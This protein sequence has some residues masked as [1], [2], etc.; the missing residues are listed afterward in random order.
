MVG[1]RSRCY[2]ELVDTRRILIVGL[3]ALG[4]GDAADNAGPTQCD[5]GKCDNAGG[6]D[7]DGPA[8][9]CL[10]LVD[11]LS[12]NALTDEE[13]LAQ[14]DPIAQLVLKADGNCPI[15]VADIVER[16]REKDCKQQGTQV[17]SER[18]QLLGVFTDYR[19]VTELECA[20]RRVFLH[21]PILAQD[22]KEIVVP[23][24]GPP[25]LGKNIDKERLAATLD[26]TFPAIISENVDGIFNF[27]QSSS[28]IHR[29]CSPRGGF[30][31]EDGRLAASLPED[32]RSCETTAECEDGEECLQRPDEHGVVAD[33][34]YFGNSMDFVNL[35]DRDKTIEAMAEALPG[36][37]T[38]EADIEHSLTIKRNCAVCHP[39]GG[40]TMREFDSP[41][42]HWDQGSH[43]SSPQSRELIAAAPDVLGG[44]EDGFDFE[45]T[46]DAA[47][48]AYN[49]ARIRLAKELIAQ[50]SPG[51]RTF[52][53]ADLLRPLFCTDEF[54]I[55]TTGG[56]PD[57]DFTSMNFSEVITDS[58]ISPFSSIPAKHEKFEEIIEKQGW[59]L[60]GFSAGP[61]AGLREKLGIPE[62][63]E[64][65][66]TMTFITRAVIDHDYEAALVQNDIIDREFA[67]DVLK[68][69]FTRSVFSE[70]RCGLLEVVDRVDP[71]KFLEEGPAAIL[72]QLEAD[73]P[74]NGAEADFLAN[75]QEPDT[76]ANG[77]V[78][79][80][81]NVCKERPADEMLEDYLKYV[82][83]V[84]KRAAHR[85]SSMAVSEAAFLMFRFPGANGFMMPDALGLEFEPGLRFDPESCK[86]IH[87]YPGQ[88]PE[89]DGPEP[90]PD[91]T[92]PAPANDAQC[93][94]RGCDFDPAADCQCDEFCESAGDCC[95]DKTENTCE[96]D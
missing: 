63:R 3:L 5:G 78:A 9:T 49:E 85:E 58:N 33:V 35:P 87:N 57:V 36:P 72:A 18:S 41:W 23:E 92:E 20:G 19:A 45:R 56:R 30:V 7:A 68:V 1:C 34:R 93:S 51:S 14:D 46:V 40:L 16:L 55:D 8:R 29:V 17:V 73:G 12:G 2:A 70:E 77:A 95:D 42:V 48:G 82:A 81:V 10:Q 76:D 15:S 6:D 26:H 83:H 25:Q 44:F 50:E 27:Y 91:D 43:F 39:G 53:T 21:F 80:F 54:N 37:V 38:S 69:D 62:P 89:N 60:W 24:D 86:L 74:K 31:T 79:A 66:G 61:F 71:A 88:E 47:N 84:R 75:L 59:K 28:T 65:L 67:K 94:Q 4:C 22:V 11:D 52:T 13:I 90:D 64:T 32:L 96:E